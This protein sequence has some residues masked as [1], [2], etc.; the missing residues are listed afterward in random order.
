MCELW[1][2]S[3]TSSFFRFMRE[4]FPSL[5]VK[6]KEKRFAEER[7]QAPIHQWL[8]L[9]ERE[10]FH[11][12]GKELVKLKDRMKAFDGEMYSKEDKCV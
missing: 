10:W 5:Y 2:E 11:A 3:D 6:E 1:K 8:T 12:S 4:T 7:W 9:E